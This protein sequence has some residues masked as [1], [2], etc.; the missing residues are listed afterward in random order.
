MSE[1]TCHGCNGRGWA[2][3]AISAVLCPVCK[4]AGMLPGES[5]PPVPTYVPYQPDIY[6]YL[7]RPYY[8]C[9]YPGVIYTYSNRSCL[10]P[11]REH[12]ARQA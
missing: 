7:L 1:R 4:G 8:Y 11:C 5:I 2:E 12:A 3:A 9:I 6:P 10:T